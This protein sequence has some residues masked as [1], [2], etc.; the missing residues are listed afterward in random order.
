[1]KTLWSSMFW[2]ECTVGYSEGFGLFVAQSERCNRLQGDSGMLKQVFG[3]GVF[4]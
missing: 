4:C 2:E 3:L 1:M